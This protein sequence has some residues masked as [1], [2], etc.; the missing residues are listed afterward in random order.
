MSH[1]DGAAAAAVAARLNGR[2]ADHPLDITPYVAAVRRFA[3]WALA[4]PDERRA[5]ARRGAG[6]N[7]AA[8][9]EADRNRRFVALQYLVKPPS[10]RSETV[11]DVTG[12]RSGRSST[13]LSTDRVLACGVE[14][15]GRGGA[16]HGSMVNDAAGQRPTR[17]SMDKL[18]ACPMGGKGSSGEDNKENAG[19]AEGPAGLGSKGARERNALVKRLLEANREVL[20]GREALQRFGL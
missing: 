20:I 13:R 14:E 15:R 17:S 3:D 8:A 5:R 1:P 9:A 10:S 4:D 18:F 2:D 12:Q 19:C 6:G 11:D 7:L 16:R